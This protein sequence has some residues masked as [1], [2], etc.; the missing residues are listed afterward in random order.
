MARIQKDLQALYQGFCQTQ[1]LWNTNVI[2]NIAQYEFPEDFYSEFH[3]KLER[4]V[5]LGQ[6]AE[7]FVF[8]QIEA[9]DHTELLAENI[10]IQKGKHTQG[11]LDA[12]LLS[13]SDAIHLEIIYK[14]YVYDVT[15]IRSEIHHWIGPNRK[16]SLIDKL[17][18][19][20]DKQL[21]L[22]HSS[23]CKNTLQRLKLDAFDFK[24]RVLFKAQLFLPYQK[25][26]EFDLL[27]KNCISGFYLNVPQLEIFK[28]DSFYIPEKLDWFLHPHVNVEWM[29]YS[30][31]REKATAF[32]NKNQSPLFWLRNK[33]GELTKVFL[34]WW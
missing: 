11:E 30:N 24:Q 12:L 3:R 5:R 18:K 27:N 23:D 4:N 8:N 21:P 31:F 2:Q 33:N 34:V 17:Y 10:Q 20:R 19:L 32:L 22:L 1:S 13:H 26:V 15:R 16:D 7:Q 25:H 28:A 9:Y 6:L 14:F 29:N